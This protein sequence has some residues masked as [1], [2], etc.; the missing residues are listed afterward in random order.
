[1]RKPIGF[2]RPSQ[3]LRNRPQPKGK[4]M[5][6]PS[7]KTNQQPVAS[8]Q[9]PAETSGFNYAT[10]DAADRRFALDHAATIK[11]R[12]GRTV[13]AVI[14]IGQSLA[15]VKE[16]IGHGHFMAWIDAEFGMSDRSARRLMQ[17]A[18]SFKLATVAN[19]KIE[20]TALYALASGA[21]PDAAREEALTLAQ[22][23]ESITTAK[24]REIIARHQGEQAPTAAATPRPDTA[25]DVIR[26]LLPDFLAAL[27][28]EG[29]LSV[30]H[31]AELLTLK[32]DFGKA[33]HRHHLGQY[34]PEQLAE[35][36]PIDCILTPCRPEEW[37]LAWLDWREPM[38]TEAPALVMDA[39]KKF[40]A[41]YK[42]AGG[43]PRWQVFAFWW[44]AMAAMGSGTVERLREHIEAWRRRFQFALV[45]R[46]GKAPPVN[47]HMTIRGQMWW[48]C[49]QDLSWSGT[50]TKLAG[51]N[52]PE[53]RDA[54]L[55]Q[56][57]LLP[58][59]GEWVAPVFP[60]TVLAM[61]FFE[62]EKAE[63]IGFPPLPSMD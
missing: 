63:S 9:A 58:T 26:A 62:P 7:V 60:S 56:L 3:N 57:Q 15:A 14:E 13:Q 39:A 55:D 36:L 8:T 37:S 47:E 41:A 43:L 32:D 33:I 52:G 48:G 29:G 44:G 51:E 24:A 42:E 35:E 31:V 11:D 34:W 54:L 4:D 12:M 19:L 46:M 6:K 17:T 40:A 45:M 53:W 38:S 49:G 21:T 27:V 2:Y 61:Q 10:L 25:A 23:G 5:A 20:S 1:M 16:R 50:F 28:R 30:E 22:S 59:V 18:E